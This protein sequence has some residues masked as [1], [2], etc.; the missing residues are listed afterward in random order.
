MPL[1]IAKPPCDYIEVSQDLSAKATLESVLGHPENRFNYISP[2][3]HECIVRPPCEAD[4]I[5]RDP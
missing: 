5:L 2:R 3:H 1:S 4:L